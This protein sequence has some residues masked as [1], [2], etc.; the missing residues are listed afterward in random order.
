MSRPLRNALFATLVALHA[1]V[2]V[3]GTG[4][5]A[6]PGMG[7]DAGLRPLAKNDHSHGPGKSAHESADEC[8]V[9][10]FLAQGQ[11]SADDDGGAVAR[12]PGDPVTLAKAANDPVAPPGASIPRAP[13]RPL[14]GPA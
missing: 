9:C 12:R 1:A 8:P 3:C 14:S 4:L 11:L 5:H 2:T 13:P 10:Q 6:L 7:H